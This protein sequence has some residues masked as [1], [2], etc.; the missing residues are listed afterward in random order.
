MTAINV[1]GISEKIPPL[2]IIKKN[3][4]VIYGC[5]RNFYHWIWK[6]FLILP[7]LIMKSQNAS[8]NIS[9]VGRFGGGE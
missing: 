6:D 7:R 2:E 9:T 1:P 5:F 8:L 4:I 3:P